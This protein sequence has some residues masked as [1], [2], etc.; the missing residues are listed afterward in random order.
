MP[1]GVPPMIRYWGAIQK[2]SHW[3]HAISQMRN[4]NMTSQLCIKASTTWLTL[5]TNL[6]EQ[7]VYLHRSGNIATD[8]RGDTLKWTLHGLAAAP[9]APAFKGLLI[10]DCFQKNW[11]SQCSLLPPTYKTKALQEPNSAKYLLSCRD[12]PQHSWQRTDLPSPLGLPPREDPQELDWK[13]LWKEKKSKCYGLITLH[14]HCCFFPRA[15]SPHF[16]LSTL[17]TALGP[18]ILL[19]A[20]GKDCSYGADGERKF[21]KVLSLAA[22][23]MP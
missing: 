23:Q 16:C 8:L 17:E 7:K 4:Q 15:S 19:P 18:S 21:L 11:K 9:P 12:I 6:K 1:I 20:T 13:G 2:Q 3:V 14:G 10:R 22:S 5:G